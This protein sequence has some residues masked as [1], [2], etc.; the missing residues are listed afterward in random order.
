MTTAA[1]QPQA[2]ELGA[3][4][5]LWNDA[6][7]RLMRTW[8]TRLCLAII[9]FFV[10][11][12][13]AGVVYEWAAAAGLWGAVPF[14][15]AMNFDRTNQ[16]PSAQSLDTLLGTDWA[17]RSVLLKTVLG[18]KVSLTVGLMANVIAVPLGMLLGAL[19]GYHGKRVDDV[20]VWLYTTLSC[21]PGIILLIALKYA[22]SRQPVLGLDLS[23]IHGIYVALG[24]T[25]WVGTC[26]LARA[27]V[28]KI[29]ELDYV[30]SARA[31]GSRS[32][33]ILLRHVMPNIA[34]IGIISFSL[35][36][37]AA[38]HSEVI[39]SYLG[40]GVDIGTPSWGNMINSA[41]QDLMAGRWWELTAAV[42]AM[43]LLVLALNIFGD[44]LR[45]A[46]DPRLRNL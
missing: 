6:W 11:L 35:G 1:A 33:L 31:I 5:T 24:V 7:R 12:A 30:T 15:D 38:V 10:L 28:M 29:R 21:I 44:R 32:G 22:F 46:L 2:M 34:H 41:R 37:V 4:R 27:E 13:L 26:R 42:G 43:F 14:R 16:P 9:V 40:L 18:A 8:E 36:M 25:S 45:D 19:A 23:G 17:G 39:L 20:I 3:G